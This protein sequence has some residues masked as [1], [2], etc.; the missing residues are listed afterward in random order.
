MQSTLSCGGTLVI[1]SGFDLERVLAAIDRNQVT[2]FYAVTTVYIRLLGVPNLREKIRSVRYCFSA[3]ASMAM[4]EVKE[5]KTETGLDIYEAYGMTESAS[6][7]TY[8]HYYRHMIGS[9][10]TPVNLVD[11]EIRDFGGSVLKQGEKG[12][13]CVRGPN[14]ARG[15]L[16]NP[17]ETERVFWGDWFRSGDIGMMDENGCLYIV[18]CLK[19]MIV[20]GG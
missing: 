14:I 16:N 6:M 8:N 17:E 9:V 5:W 10:G 1:Q 2:K 13:I 15:Y 18:D 20:T 11:I 19:D 3:A 7:V 4:E 12:E